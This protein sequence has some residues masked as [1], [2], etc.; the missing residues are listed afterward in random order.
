MKK[1]FTGT[2]LTI[3]I[4]GLLFCCVFL[5]DLYADELNSCEAMRE[6]IKLKDEQ[7]AARNK[8]IDKE[9]GTNLADPLSLSPNA[10]QV[11]RKYRGPERQNKFNI[12]SEEECKEIIVPLYTPDGH[13]FGDISYSAYDAICCEQLQKYDCL[14]DEE[15][16]VLHS[17]MNYVDLNPGMSLADPLPIP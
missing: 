10:E 17:Y 11:E 2:T 5:N 7:I 9:L 3:L 13:Y 6:Q 12:M 14:S 15:M 1:I 16:R 8:I 4:A